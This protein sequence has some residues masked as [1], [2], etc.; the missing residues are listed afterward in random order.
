MA[1]VLVATVSVVVGSVVLSR[2][3]VSARRIGVS[4][5]LDAAAPGASRGERSHWGAVV[6]PAIVR[7]ALADAWPEADASAVWTAWLTCTTTLALCGVGFYG[8]GAGASA[9]VVAA[10]AGAAGLRL[11]RGRRNEIVAASVAP[12]LESTAR[13]LRSGAALAV[14][15]AEAGSESGG[16]L[17]EEVRRAALRHRAGVPLAAAIGDIEARLPV[18]E[19]R[20]AVTALL[21]GLETGGELAPSLDGVAA[22]VR[23]QREVAAEARALATQARASALMLAAAPP[24]FALV[25][26]A[27]GSGAT[28]FL[29]GTVPGLVC[30][31]VALV[32]DAIGALWMTRIAAGAR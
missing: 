17:G 16:P 25:M 2:L 8:P 14:A 10:V 21:V 29:L 15:L 9:V 32:L 27:A 18:R 5:R 13:G 31:M 7:R 4:R 12:L 6:V 3:G 23:D 26:G 30:L 28:S 11:A 22:T 19:V 20:L 24:V 1:P